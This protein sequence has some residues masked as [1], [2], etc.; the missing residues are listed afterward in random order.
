[1][2]GGGR[3]TRSGQLRDLIMQR[4]RSR[5]RI[6]HIALPR[7]GPKSTR[8]ETDG[9]LTMLRKVGSGVSTFDELSAGQSQKGRVQV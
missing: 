4:A 7:D 1:M 2:K 6:V 8:L 9:L 5:P 3:K